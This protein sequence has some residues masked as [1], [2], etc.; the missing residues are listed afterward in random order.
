MGG[1]TSQ[2]KS[3]S[4]DE[5][6]RTLVGGSSLEPDGGLEAQD[7]L[8]G[9]LMIICNQHLFSLYAWDQVGTFPGYG[10]CCEF[11]D[12]L[13]YSPASHRHLQKPRNVH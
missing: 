3:G 1:L 6:D 12:G 10:S 11:Q 9:C 2:G 7:P 4:W 13:S 5:G 8:G